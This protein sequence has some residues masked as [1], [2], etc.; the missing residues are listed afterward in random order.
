MICLDYNILLETCQERQ[1][2]IRTIKNDSNYSILVIQVI[3]KEYK[4]GTS[5][6]YSVVTRKAN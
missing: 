4:L 6:V 2:P 3:G 5:S 1:R